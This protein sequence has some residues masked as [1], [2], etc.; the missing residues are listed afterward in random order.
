MGKVAKHLEGR[1]RADRAKV[2]KSIGT[3]KQLTVQPKTRERYTKARKGFYKFLQDNHLRLPS[4]REDLDS[5]L[6]EYIEFL[7]ETGEGRALASDTVAG[8][9]DLDPKLRG[10]LALTWRLLKTWHVS[11]VPNRAPPL[12]ESALRAM[13]GWSIFHG[14]DDFAVSLM[15]GFYG[16]LRT[17]EI[18]S[19]TAS[20]VFLAKASK[21]A[22][23][24]LGMTKGGKR[25]GA[26]ESVT[27]HVG[28]AL[29]LLYKW[30]KRVS[31]HA[32]LVQSSHHWRTLYATCLDK[33]GLS[34]FGFR[35]YS[36]RRGGA[37]CWFHRHGN[38][39]KLL[40]LG[41]WQA[42]KTARIY[43]NDGLSMLA[44]LKLP[45]QKL[46]PFQDVY[47]NSFRAAPKLEQT[48]RVVWG[49][50]EECVIFNFR[51]LFT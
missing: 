37:T 15:L 9:Q 29:Q 6:A 49:D 5:L 16:L 39:D 2:R 13:V 40:I 38:F 51:F 34:S 23:V 41:R 4:K 18:L 27:I 47:S 11:E 19:L 26:A 20:S 50:V 14:H 17:G 48:L 3:L 25:V 1:T 33:L 30:K 31:D 43:I 7:W 42:A 21:L 10:H 36:L 35:P 12:P 24:S 46:K 44:E 32:P 22:V 8:V 45:A 28:D